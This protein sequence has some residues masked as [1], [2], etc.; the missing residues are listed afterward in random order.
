MFKKFIEDEIIYLKKLSESDVGEDYYNWINDSEV[1]NYTVAWL[2]PQSLNDIKNYVI[3]INNDPNNELF[4]ICLKDGDK[5]IWNIKLGSINFI[6]G[7]A[8]L[9]IFIW[10]K[11]EW[12]K[13]YASN[14][15]NLLK[16]YAFKKLNLHKLYAGAI[17]KNI[18]SIKT[19]QKCWFVIVWEKKEQFYVDWEYCNQIL[20][21]CMRDYSS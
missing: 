9:S 3:N 20:F 19:L 17:H 21:D 1:N 12:W 10:D 18:W 16:I 11:S 4:A 7:N 8:E 2:R 5:H 15:I 6:N 13:W 14:A